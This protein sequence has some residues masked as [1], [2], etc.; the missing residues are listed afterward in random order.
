MSDT[1]PA[2]NRVMLCLG[3]EDQPYRSWVLNAKGRRVKGS[4]IP[5]TT[6]EVAEILEAKYGLFSAFAKWQMPFIQRVVEESVK[7]AINDLITTGHAT[8]PWG[9]ATQAI[10]SRFRDFIA[11]GMAE[12]IGLR[13]VPTQAALHGVH[14]RYA[15]PYSRKNPRRPS[16]DDTGIMMASFR[17][18]MTRGSGS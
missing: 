7:G 8:D 9:S 10:E 11:T 17:A 6:H 18:W 2:G 1:I 4:P 15:H 5:M 16:F 3:V 14:H 12:R 13:G